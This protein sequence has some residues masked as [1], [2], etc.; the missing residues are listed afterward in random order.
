MAKRK[1][2]VSIKILSKQACREHKVA[3]INI[4]TLTEKRYLCLPT[5]IHI[6]TRNWTDKLARAFLRNVVIQMYNNLS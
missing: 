4:H 5:E 1:S 6:D 3:K 2:W